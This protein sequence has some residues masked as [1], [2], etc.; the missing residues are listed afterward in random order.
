[1]RSYEES[2][3]KALKASHLTSCGT[4]HVIQSLNVECVG[5]TGVKRIHQGWIVD[6]LVLLVQVEVLHRVLQVDLVEHIQ[7]RTV[8]AG[9][10]PTV[11]VGRMF[12]ASLSAD[13]VTASETVRSAN[14]GSLPK[15]LVNGVVLDSWLEGFEL[16]GLHAT[17]AGRLVL[18]A[19]HTATLAL[20]LLE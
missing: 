2:Q 9:D 10:E 5:S 1:M 14:H 12:V 11:A 13:A 20:N 8:D 6:Q 16:R 15:Q 19:N 3:P 7:A 4:R 17:E 18:I